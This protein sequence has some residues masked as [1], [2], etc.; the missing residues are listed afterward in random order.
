MMEKFEN[1]GKFLVNVVAACLVFW[2]V[3]GLVSL[4]VAFLIKI[5]L[6][7]FICVA[8]ISLALVITGKYNKVEAFFNKI[9]RK[10]LGKI[11]KPSVE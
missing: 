9:I 4:V 2:A 11:K 5:E 3:T 1:A 7:L 8:A 10:V 6:K